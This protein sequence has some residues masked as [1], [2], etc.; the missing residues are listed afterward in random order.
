MRK[1]VNSYAKHANC[2]EK[3]RAEHRSLLAPDEPL[4]FDRLDDIALTEMA[5]KEALRLMPPVPSIPRRAL[6]EFEFKGFP[7]SGIVCLMSRNRDATLCGVRWERL[8][9]RLSFSSSMQSAFN[10]MPRKRASSRLARDTAKK[11][12]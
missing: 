11:S 6:R 2:Q 4:P 7:L 8:S 5:F 1:T 12:R 10:P 9:T 3:L